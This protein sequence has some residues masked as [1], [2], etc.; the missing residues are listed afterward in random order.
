M[1]PGRVHTNRESILIR[2]AKI[3]FLIK[4]GGGTFFIYF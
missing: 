3:L 1:R 2:A 4:G